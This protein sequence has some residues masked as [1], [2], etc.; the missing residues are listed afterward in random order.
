MPDVRPQRISGH[1]PYEL[2]FGFSR[3]LV[4]GDRVL[5][6][7]T[8]PVPQGGGPPPQDRTPRPGSAWT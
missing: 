2:V 1:S 6:A 7:G 5:V 8:A 4:A 3:A